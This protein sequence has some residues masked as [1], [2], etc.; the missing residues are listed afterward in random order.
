MRFLIG[1]LKLMKTKALKV[2]INL[3][4]KMRRYLIQKNLIRSDLKIQKNEKFIY[5]P[6]KKITK[7]LDSDQILIKEFKENKK[8][9]KSY[10]DVISIPDKLKNRLPTSF[11]ILGDIILLKLNENILDYK[12]E[13]GDALLKTNK[14]I[15]T[16]CLIQPISGE[17]RKRNVEIISG[18]NKTETIHTEYGLRFFIDIKKAYFSPR[19]ANERKRITNFV[20]KGETIVDLFAGVAPFSIMIA[21]YSN[22]KIIY[23]IDKNKDAI[24]LA[25]K[26]ITLNKLIHKIE[27]IN[28]DAKMIKNIFQKKNIKADR[29]IMNLPFSAHLFFKD[30]LK[31]ASDKCIIH[32]YDIL[33]EDRIQER[34]NFL[35]QIA[36]QCNYSLQK[37]EINKIKTYAPREFYIGIDITARKMDADVA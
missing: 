7:G 30:A 22:P 3:A 36:R 4:E 6:L 15:K 35:K 37:M 9:T 17:F 14:N 24:E 26:N 16:V 25:K 18:K 31:I 21:R 13:I 1:I 12:H 23:A 8:K 19:L 33:K 34:V 11:D 28:A 10:K 2:D 5:F 32:Y 20:N 29:T 27:A